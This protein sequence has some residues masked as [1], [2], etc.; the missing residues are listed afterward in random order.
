MP[1]R[2]GLPMQIRALHARKERRES[3]IQ[4]PAPIDALRARVFVYRA[5]S[6]EIDGPACLI[7]PAAERARRAPPVSRHPPTTVDYSIGSSVGRAGDEIRAHPALTEE[8]SPLNPEP[9]RS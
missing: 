5:L 6:R 7:R 1:P 3:P 4:E 8:A 2:L 9:V